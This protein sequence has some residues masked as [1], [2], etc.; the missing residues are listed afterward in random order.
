MN[1]ETCF[2]VLFRFVQYCTKKVTTK[3]NVVITLK[4][5]EISFLNLLALKNEKKISCLTNIT[6]KWYSILIVDT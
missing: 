2:D 4:I 1:E 6:I 5:N 3:T